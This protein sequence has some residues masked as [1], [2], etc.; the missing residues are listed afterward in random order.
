VRRW[1][2]GFVLVLGLFAERSTASPVVLTG[3]VTDPPGAPLAGVQV[4][5]FAAGRL[6][7]AALSDSGGRYEVAFPVELA[8]D[9]T[10]VVWWMPAT[11]DK[12]PEF[13]ILRESRA[14]L[15]A[16]LFSRCLPRR[17]LADSMVF[18]P[19][20]RGEDEKLEELRESDCLPRSDADSSAVRGTVGS[21]DR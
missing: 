16:K 5:A 20:L 3:R 2:V 9:P 12:V 7:A 15:E 1:L 14:A 6:A 11:A 13:L 19:V 17:A 4:R 10:V 21:G 18:D 8:E